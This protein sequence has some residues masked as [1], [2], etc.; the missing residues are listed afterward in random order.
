MPIKK[1]VEY[2]IARLKDKNREVRLKAIQELALLADPDSLEVLH[3]VFKS[4][5][6]EEVRKAAQQ[7]GR[8][9]FTKSRPKAKDDKSTE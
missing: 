7:A 2:H 8:E 3:E 1:L 9:V 5:P 4:D 6:D